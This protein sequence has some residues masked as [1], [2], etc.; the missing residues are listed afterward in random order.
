MTPNQELS[1][2]LQQ[3][4]VWTY[5]DLCQRHTTWLQNTALVVDWASWARMLK[6]S[7]SQLL[8]A[9]IRAIRQSLT[10]GS[11]VA[12]LVRVN[13]LRMGWQSPFKSW[14][15]LSTHHCLCRYLSSADTPHVQIRAHTSN[16]VV[17]SVFCRYM[18]STATMILKIV[19]V[20][21]LSLLSH[22]SPNGWVPSLMGRMSRLGAVCR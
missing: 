12:Y 21:R 2:D 4:Q 11:T 7:T 8:R 18:D 13:S 16:L 5:A 17:H 14:S 19:N 3:G 22:G 9:V 20:L 10:T 15:P 6:G 1:T